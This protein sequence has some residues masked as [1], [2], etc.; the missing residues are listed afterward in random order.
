MVG[1]S[2]YPDVFDANRILYKKVQSGTN[3]YF[4]YSTNENDNLFTVTFKNV[5]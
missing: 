2:A 5:G 4:E 1:E 3:D